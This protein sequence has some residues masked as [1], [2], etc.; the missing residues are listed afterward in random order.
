MRNSD[1]SFK[2]ESLQDTASIQS[3]LKAITK[4]LAEGRLTFSDEDGEIV[5]EP[6]GLLQLKFSA[7][8]ENSLSKINLRISWQVEEEPKQK[9]KPISVK[10]GGKD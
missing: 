5:M 1:S 6:E 9:R 4:G 3:L 8:R 7:T 10:T 2:H